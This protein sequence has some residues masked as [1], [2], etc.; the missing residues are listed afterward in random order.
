MKKILR[1]YTKNVI[2]NKLLQ[3]L[4]SLSHII[5]NINRQSNSK[6]DLVDDVNVSDKTKEGND[7]N[8]EEEETPL[9]CNM[10]LSNN[11]NT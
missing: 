3:L 8:E 11:K 1:D 9:M 4:Y 2:R 6:L 7:I 5:F 10:N